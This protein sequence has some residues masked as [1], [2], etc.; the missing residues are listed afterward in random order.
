MTLVFAYSL[1]VLVPWALG[2]YHW[3]AN[4]PELFYG[5]DLSQ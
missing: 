1:V 5:K 3:A 4:T 2:V